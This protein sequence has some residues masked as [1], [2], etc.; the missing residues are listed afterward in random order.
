MTFFEKN[1]NTYGKLDPTSSL[2]RGVATLASELNNVVICRKGIVDIV[3]NGFQTY[4]VAMEGGLKRS[5]GQG[6]ILAGVLGTF[7]FFERNFV[8]YDD[9]G[10]RMLLAA[11]SASIV[12]R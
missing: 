7:A 2:A 10:D 9:E 5:G 11:V 4:F 3:S 6:D 12:T 1:K 8:E